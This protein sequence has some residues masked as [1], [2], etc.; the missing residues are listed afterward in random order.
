METVIAKAHDLVARAR[1]GEDVVRELIRHHLALRE[2]PWS[3]EAYAAA[4]GVC[5]ALFGSASREAV[6]IVLRDMLP[7][8]FAGA[9]LRGMMFREEDGLRAPFAASPWALDGEEESI[10]AAIIRIW[11]AAPEAEPLAVELARRVVGLALFEH[12]QQSFLAYVVYSEMDC[13][14]APA[15]DRPP[16]T[17]KAA[18]AWQP[19]GDVGVVIGAAPTLQF[20]GATPMPLRSFYRVHGGLRDGMWSLASPSELTRWSDMLGHGGPVQCEDPGEECRAEDLLSF[21]SYGDDRTD[22]F[23]LTRSGRVRA[24]GDG[25]L[26]R[27]AWGSFSAWLRDHVG[28]LV[29]AAE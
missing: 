9:A 25:V 24:W 17:R 12:E 29:G 8:G 11:S 2:L 20:P 3:S 14:K 1:A 19:F 6:E 16:R 23:E 13:Y 7:R 18:L 27:R 15:G 28:L 21:F 10:D 4:R 26:Y 5:L 22:L